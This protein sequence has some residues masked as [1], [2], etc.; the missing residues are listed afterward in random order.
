[1]KTVSTVDIG[2]NV[3]YVNED[4][5]EI[6]KNY[7]G[8]IRDQFLN[9]D[10]AEE[11]FSDIEIR[12]A[13]ILNNLMGNERQVI[14][15]DAV[16][17]LMEEMGQPE[18]FSEETPR[19][20]NN[21]INQDVG[22]LRKRLYLDKKDKMLSGVCSGIGAYLRIDPSIIRIVFTYLILFGSDPVWIGVIVFYMMLSVALP[23]AT[24]A[25]QR[26]EM[27]GGGWKLSVSSRG[28]ND[29]FKNLKKTIKG[30]SIHTET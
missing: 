28:I 17:E 23:E 11:D 15:M 27:R 12:I 26:R 13:E 19:V 14:T 3:F 4:V 25:A 9:A 18:D 6:L 2:G 8:R 22:K 10:G 30:K 5:Y 20:A 29:I 16:R 21:E 1:M 7:F 24:T